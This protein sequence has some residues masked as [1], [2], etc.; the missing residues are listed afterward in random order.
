[1]ANSGSEARHRGVAVTE[2]TPQLRE[3]IA[4][5]A[6][7]DGTPPA[8]D[9]A[10]L[11]VTQG[12]RRLFDFDG[13]ALGIVGEGELDLVVHPA[14][15]G[16][17]LGG[18]A[19]GQLLDH[20]RAGLREHS[21]TTGDLRAW[22]H[23]ENPAAESL[24]RGAD[25][26]A[27]RTLLRMTLEPT[28]L[29]G[30]IEAARALPVGFVVVPF[31][32]RP[33]G[34]DPQ[35]TDSPNA[36]LQGTDSPKLNDSQ[37]DDWVRVNAAA[38][39]DHPEQGAMTRSDFDVLTQESWFDPNDLRLAYAHDDAATG[40]TELAAFAWVK[41]TR[42]GDGGDGGASDSVETELYALGAHP[43]FAGRGLGA[44]MLGE[45]LRRMASHHPTRI[46]LY[47][48]GDNAAALPLYERAGFEIEQ[49]S[50]QWLLTAN[51]ANTTGTSTGRG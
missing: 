47:V 21:N 35:G 3:V 44:A 29:P 7:F 22:A 13:K 5:A 49:R 18:Q 1:M 46:T 32:T 28:K 26:A 17:G 14:H 23:G 12:K 34:A 15:R 24:L 39:A 11:A 4:A 43:K 31:G 30:A 25:F 19:L 42:G 40:A 8:S 48:E 9:Q 10:L 16:Q 51:A 20:W 2:L 6:Q 38:F 37:A 45:T 41:T 33:L 27:V 50:T 36:G